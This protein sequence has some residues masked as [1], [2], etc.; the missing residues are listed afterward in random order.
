MVDI[1]REPDTWMDPRWGASGHRIE[2]TLD[3]SFPIITL[4]SEN[5]RSSSGENREEE[6]VVTLASRD[7]ATSLLKCV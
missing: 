4:S 6:V 5:N 2:F 3:V 7:I 1:G